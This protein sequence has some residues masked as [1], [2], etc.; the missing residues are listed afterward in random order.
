[1][2]LMNLKTICILSLVS[3]M[4]AGCGGDNQPYPRLSTIPERPKVRLTP[5]EQEKMK[6]SLEDEWEKAEVKHDQEP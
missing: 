2:A 1:M 4:L 3:F 6:A 5:I